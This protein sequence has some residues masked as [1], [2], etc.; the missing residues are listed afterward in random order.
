TGLR[1]GLARERALRDDQQ[2]CLARAR[3]Q[4]RA[5]DEAERERQ[6]AQAR[7][8]TERQARRRVEAALDLEG[9]RESLTE[10]E[11]CPLCGATDHPYAT[12]VPAVAALLKAA[13]EAERESRDAFERWVAQVA[14]HEAQ[15][16]ADAVRG[17]SLGEARERERAALGE[18]AVAWDAGLE[19]LAGLAG[20]GSRAGDVARAVAALPRAAVWALDG[21]SF[22]GDSQ[23]NGASD[24]ARVAVD[25]VHH[26]VDSLDAAAATLDMARGALDEQL[27]HADALTRA[28]RD[29]HD[30]LDRATTACSERRSRGV[31]A[32]E[33]LTALV[34]QDARLVE[35]AER[36]AAEGARARGEVEAR[37][38]QD[39]G[40]EA[41]LLADASAF[42]TERG[43]RVATYRA[44]VE[45]LDAARQRLPVLTASLSGLAKD[46]ASA[47]AAVAG[48]EGQQAVAEEA[49]AAVVSAREAL[50]GGAA[51]RT[52]EALLAAVRAA[53]VLARERD[54][55]AREHQ[56]ARPHP[57]V[58]MDAEGAQGQLQALVAALDGAREQQATLAGRLALD[59]TQ[60]QARAE[61]GPALLTQRAQAERW[62]RLNQLVGQADGARFRDF[63]QGLTLKIVLEHANQRLR[64][65]RPRYRLAV[66]P[67]SNLDIQVVDKDMG[68]EV[69]SIASLSG[70]E[71]F[72][73]SLA[74]A[75]G[76]S[77]STGASSVE[78]LF[79][80]EGFGTLDSEAFEVAMSTL[81]ALQASGCI[82]GVISH[83]EGLADRVGVRAEVQPQG[84]GLSRVRVVAPGP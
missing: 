44:Q 2:A 58:V 67:G 81:D 66:V 57:Q 24:D 33:R 77:E 29:A 18:Q 80:D 42:L 60:R 70:G 36:A 43:Q 55:K 56:A 47:R 50:F 82:I 39:G 9:H 83:V 63:A 54:A 59:D 14:T 12:Q 10:G 15:R 21:G 28:L 76:L 26:A 51:A 11:P 3:E 37:V 46:V 64:E 17:Q 84:G 30:A 5:R 25:A 27:R 20:L 40:W 31:T 61:L 78:T 6:L 62:E 32:G 74:L 1:A 71:T 68:D 52:V 8:D 48:L 75:L 35:Q 41:A 49:L 45:A 13:Q 22:A 69:R 23:P 65:L 34:A 4:H 19:G 7:Y 79:I 38:G 53:E 72:L 73:V 16:E